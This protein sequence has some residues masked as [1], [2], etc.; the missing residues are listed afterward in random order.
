MQTTVHK[1]HCDGSSRRGFT[2]I[3]VL[4]VLVIIS[5]LMALLFPAFQ[6]AQ[7]NG[8]QASCQSN[9]SRFTWPL[10][11]IR[12]T[13]GSTRRLWQYCCRLRQD[14]T[15]S[16]CISWDP[17]LPTLAVVLILVTKSMSVA[18]A[19]M[20]MLVRTPV[21][22]GIWRPVFLRVPTTIWTTSCARLTAT[23][24]LHWAQI[25]GRR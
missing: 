6:R 18:Q 3:E 24:R 14:Q 10:R 15:P 17:A 8:R 20:T 5:I 7:E 22:P 12:T 1:H 9:L 4:I 23:S 16:R 19:Q 25:P 21:V 11:S 13:S 2:L